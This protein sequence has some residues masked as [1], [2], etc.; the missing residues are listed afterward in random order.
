MD[1]FRG[2]LAHSILLQT[3]EVEPGEKNEEKYKKAVP[4][5]LFFFA[6]PFFLSLVYFFFAFTSNQRAATIA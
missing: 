3:N 6:F 1:I 2:S 4:I 5:L